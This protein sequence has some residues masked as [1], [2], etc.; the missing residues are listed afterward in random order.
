MWSRIRSF[1]SPSP[2]WASSNTVRAWRD[3]R[4]CP[5]PLFDQGRP[6]D[7]LQVPAYDRASGATG[8]ILWSRSNSRS[9]RSLRPE[10]ERRRIRASEVSPLRVSCAELL[11]DDLELFVQVVLRRS[12]SIFGASP[13]PADPRSEDLE[14]P[15]EDPEKV[16]R[17][18]SSVGSSR[19]ALLLTRREQK[20]SGDE[21]AEPGRAPSR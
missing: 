12:P 13:G 6:E 18:P 1:T 14:L 15:F 16:G 9:A 11:L 4:R 10:V 2:K 17:A 3:V 8:L 19:R 21:V 5:G 7:P 20:V